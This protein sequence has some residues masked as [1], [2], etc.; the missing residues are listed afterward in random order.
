MSDEIGT[1]SF[2][3]WLRQGLANQV[4]APA[5]ADDR[6]G[7]ILVT[8]N[9]SGSG[10]TDPAD[11]PLDKE[12][13]L[14][15]PGDVIGVDPRAIV[16]S[17]PRDWITN[18]EPNYLPYVDFYDEDF[19]WRYTPSA[20]DGE[21]LVPWLTLVVL[22]EEEFEDGQNVLNRPLPYFT[23]KGATEP[24]DV[25][26]PPADL[27]AWAHVHVDRNIVGA[28]HD[29]IT[30][31]EPSFIAQFK[32]VLDENPDLA[33]ARL[34]S[35]RKLG[36]N[37]PYHAF[38]IPSFESGR[39]AG[40][41]RDPAVT[42]FNANTIAWADYPGRDSQEATAFPYYYRWYFRTGTVGDFEYLVR[43]LQPRV[44]D[45]RVGRRDIDVQD[46][47]SN[48]D[49][50]AD[51]RLKGI[52]RLG[53]ALQVPTACLDEE[54][55][56]EYT[57]YDVWYDSYPHRFQE[58]LASFINLA[59]EYKRKTTA[60]AHEESEL[61]LEDEEEEGDPD[62]LVTPPLYGRWHALTSHL[63]VEE[64]GSPAPNNENWVHDLNLDPRWRSAANFG[65][66][67]IQENQEE[68]MDAAW[69]QVGDVVEA[70]RRL[71]WAQFAGF[72]TKVWYQENI[73]PKAGVAP[74]KY[75]SLTTP[76][77]K[78]IVADGSTVYRHVQ[79]SRVPQAL[80]SAPMR[81]IIRPRGRLAR[82]LDIG[83]L[84]T[85]DNLVDRVNRGEVTPAPPRPVPDELPTNEE[86]ADV[87]KP[88][89]LPEPWLDLLLQYPWLQYLPLLLALLLLCAAL[90]VPV[91]LLVA[92]VLAVAGVA[93]F[94]FLRR[95][96]REARNANV[97]L[98]D[99][100]SPDAVDDFPRTPD[101][102]VTEL[103]DPFLPS[104]NGN[105][106]AEATRF[107]NA[108]RA[109][110]DFVQ[111]S[112]QAGEPPV[113]TELNVSQ[114]VSSIAQGLHP[115]LTIPRYVLGHI[116]VPPR[117][118][119]ALRE[120]ET[121]VEAMAYPEIDVPMYK[122]LLDSSSE[123][124]V[125]NINLIEQN[126][127]TLLETNQRF[128]ES[129]MVGLNHE[130]ARELLWREYPTD[131]RGSYFRQFWDVS[132][133]LNKEG[134]SEEALR[135][136]LRDIPPLHRWSR[137]SDLGDHDHREE[138]GEKD[139]EVVLVIRGELLKKYP[140]AVVY[141][142]RARWAEDEEGN[143]LLDE[144]R[145]FDDSEPEDVVIKTP[146]Y[147]AKVDPDIYFFG[148]DL[149]VVE[150]KGDSG[151]GEDDKAGWFFVIKERPGEPRFGLD[152]PAGED[153]TAVTTLSLWN[154]L[155][156]SHLF[157]G[158]S[159]GEFITIDGTRTITVNDPGEPDP[160]SE[161]EQ[162]QKEDSFV[163]WRSALNA[164]ELAYILYQVPVLIGVHAAELLPDECEN[165]TGGSDEL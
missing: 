38:L 95:V 161:E 92:I 7:K 52:L 46:P 159:T 51:E 100:Q 115:E 58:Q 106:S 121:F 86:V 30:D 11:Q 136:K 123:K 35:P 78:R 18:F 14:Y 103:G 80:L 32:S 79:T 94:L 5:D 74:E 85:R 63:L 112:A 88:T 141:A 37:T 153:Q 134:L 101:F 15:G 84:S 39:L 22:T 158:D 109:N 131:Q 96:L 55:A 20:P 143:R 4:A 24:G 65:T 128:I 102:R 66:E 152:V 147:E 3:P 81:R 40:L 113:Y 135:E 151:E 75:L 62:P 23:L 105:D 6:R 98:P 17:E 97:I 67:V 120:Q 108:L 126:S 64:D 91:L 27:W 50:I 104:A 8:L 163:V 110:Y 71:N 1:Y 129:Y 68:Y 77:Q 29:P 70:N 41:G 45:S 117:I 140:T 144:P 122:P 12:I 60:A 132:S 160:D 157:A 61:E 44:A 25:F 164:A 21:R 165:G 73:R 150:A 13:E 138:G 82:R 56:E 89:T 36:E 72:A 48:V 118:A 107:K 162:Q 2:L 9:I 19:P 26:P 53:G 114:M 148:F 28:G 99:N 142:H 119:D 93:A 43:L 16:K 127:I 155:A 130:F 116:S 42:G 146:L 87:V 124:F 54:E 156:W 83:P 59:E 10:L 154:E 133:F 31:D 47:G 125:P 137:T 149:N 139:E 69:E 90:L 111:R 34:L 57:N 49:G 145:D 76:L 33:H